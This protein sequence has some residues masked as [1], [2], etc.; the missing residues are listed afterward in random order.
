M[1]KDFERKWAAHLEDHKLPNDAWVKE[2]ARC[3]YEFGFSDGVI[4]GSV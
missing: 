2:L 3:F 4:N 1:Q